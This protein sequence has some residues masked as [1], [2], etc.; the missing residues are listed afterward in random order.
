MV[1]TKYITCSALTFLF[2]TGLRGLFQDSACPP[3]SINA[4]TNHLQPVPE[5]DEFD[6][7]EAA[8]FLKRLDFQERRG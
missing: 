6:S 4:D 2:F 3:P 5:D 1:N 8:G 7:M